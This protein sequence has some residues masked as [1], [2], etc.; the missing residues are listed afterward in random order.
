MCEQLKKGGNVS[1]SHNA[2]EHKSAFSNS[3]YFDPEG[4][5][6]QN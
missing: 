5:K 2:I 4:L 3:N 1:M 6:Q